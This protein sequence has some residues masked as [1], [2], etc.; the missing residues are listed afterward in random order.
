MHYLTYVLVRRPEDA[1]E[2]AA[3]LL[4][5]SELDPA[6]SFASFQLPCSCCGSLAMSKGYAAFESSLHGQEVMSA[7]KALRQGAVPGW[8]PQEV[9]LLSERYLAARKHAAMQGDFEQPDP[10][11]DTC[12]GT[13][14][15]SA[16][17]DPA[18]HHD[19]WAIGGRWAHLFTDNVAPF[20]AAV[21]ART[22]TAVVTA[23][24]EWHEEGSLRTPAFLSDP[25]SVER[26]RRECLPWAEELAALVDA[27]Q[28]HYAVVVDCHL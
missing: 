15:Y 25:E 16:S 8:E 10:E 9:Q 4:A 19:W 23:S 12:L 21:Q 18:Q 24:G 1:A 3:R 14:R 11:C 20:Q 2:T 22:P 27:Y 6:R 7:L 13:G 26:L 17:R 5:G 28:D